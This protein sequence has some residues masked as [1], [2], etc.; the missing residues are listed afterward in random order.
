MNRLHLLLA[1]S[2]LSVF[3]ISL[4]T[5]SQAASTTSSR[6]GSERFFLRHN[7]DPDNECSL[8]SEFLSR[9]DG[10]DSG[11][12]CTYSLSPLAPVA[13][14][15]P[16]DPTGGMLFMKEIFP[17]RFPRGTATRYLDARKK[18]QG[19]IAIASVTPF[20][21]VKLDIVA[22]VNGRKLPPFHLD[23]GVKPTPSVFA[24]EPAATF[25]VRIPLP[26]RLQG[27]PLRSLKLTVIWRQSA[28]VLGSTWIEMER[29]SSYVDIPTLGVS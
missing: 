10:P 28:S 27:R 24:D 29:P 17:A 23:T 26:G 18:I 19:E 22:T 15:L 25:P 4:A 7:G 2:A 20:P 16:S 3:S 11:N 8:E 9:T 1:L 5:D 21:A 6:T 14:A 13:Q 12:G